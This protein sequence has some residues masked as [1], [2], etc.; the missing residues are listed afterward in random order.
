VITKDDSI[1]WRFTGIY[2][3]S[4]SEEEIILGKLYEPSKRKMVPLERKDVRGKMYAEVLYSPIGLRS[5]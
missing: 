3:K 5:A 1:Q 4:R 2:E